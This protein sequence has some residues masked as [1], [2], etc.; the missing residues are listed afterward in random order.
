MT[1]VSPGCTGTRPKML[2]VVDCACAPADINKEPIAMT[3][4]LRFNKTPHFMDP[5][6]YRVTI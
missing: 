4:H 1:T 2:L 6:L 3:R 5:P